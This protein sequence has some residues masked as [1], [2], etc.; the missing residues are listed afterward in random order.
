MISVIIISTILCVLMFPLVLLVR[1]KKICSKRKRERQKKGIVVG[2]FHP[3]CNAG[4][5]GERVLWAAVHA[6]QNQYVSRICGIWHHSEIHMTI[7]SI[8]NLEFMPLPFPFY[9]QISWCTHSH[10]HR[11]SLRKSWRDTQHNWKD[12]QF[13]ARAKYWIHLS[14]Q[15]KMGRGFYV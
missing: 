12:I 15:A 2:I 13:E 9:F 5:G 10:I 6:I 1:L 11:W 7:L 4:G 8:S 14:T 3:Y